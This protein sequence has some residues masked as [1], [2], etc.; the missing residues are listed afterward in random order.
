M[1]AAVSTLIS[2][3]RINVPAVG[4]WNDSTHANLSLYYHF[5]ALYADVEL[6]QPIHA[7][8]LLNTLTPQA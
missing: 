8:L 4:A 2:L 5:T 6:G 3:L 7:K 1:L